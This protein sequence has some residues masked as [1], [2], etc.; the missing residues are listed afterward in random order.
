[1]TSLGDAK[2]VWLL[3][4]LAS[5]DQTSL[6]HSETPPLISLHNPPRGQSKIGLRTISPVTKR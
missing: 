4:S 2:L 1:M 5:T 6:D 3:R